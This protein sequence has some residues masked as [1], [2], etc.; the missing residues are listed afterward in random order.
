MLHAHSKILAAVLEQDQVGFS[1]RG[2][3]NF[4]AQPTVAIA[5]D[6]LS[7][8]KAAGAACCNN[9]G[10]VRDLAVSPQICPVA[11]ASCCRSA[12]LAAF[13]DYCTGSSLLLTP[14][15]QP[16]TSTWR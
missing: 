5:A 2:A 13:A 1:W 7:P 12:A 11:S 9:C 8:L 10:A 14:C 4:T 3:H 16:N 6:I 15:W